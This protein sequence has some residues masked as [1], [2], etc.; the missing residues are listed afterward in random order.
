MATQFSR[1]HLLNGVVRSLRG[2][3]KL[4]KA[5]DTTGASLTGGDVLVRALVLRRLLRRSALQPDER[6]VGVLLPPTCAA[7]VTNLALTLDGRVVINL[8][9]TLTSTLINKCIAQAGITHV[10]TS[11]AFMER[12]PLELDGELVYLEDFK[13]AAT[14]VDKA[15]GAFQAYVMPVGLLT[16]SL[17]GEELGPDEPMTILFTSGTTG[18]PKGVVL[19]YGNVGSNVDAIDRIIKTRRPDVMLGILPFFHSFGYTVAL[20][21]VLL[22][23]VEAAYHSNPL[24][25]QV[26]GR[27][28]R[29]RKVTILIATP[30]FFRTFIRRCEPEDFRSVQAAITGA[31]RLPPEVADEFEAK[32]GMRPTQGYGCTETSPLIAATVPLHRAVPG[33][34]PPI[35]EGTVGTAAPGV[36]IKAV[37]PVTWEEVPPGERGMLLAKGPNVMAGYLDKPEETA[38][39]IRDGW[40]VTGDYATIDVEGYV[41]IVGRESRFAKIGGEMVSHLAVEEALTKIVGTTEDG[42]PRLVVVSAPDRDRGER[43]IVVHTG[44][45]QTPDELRQA[46]AA[47][48]LP[49]LYIP[50]GDSY[51]QIEEM[52]YIGTGKLDLRKI[53]E[54]ANEFAASHSRR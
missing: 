20:W 28:V 48:D 10:L 29:E 46:L 15:I 23:D 1:A 32:F 19:T 38:K 40:Y 31:E 43:L 14:A 36:A 8:N 30:M 6:R 53:R 7:A 22:N 52:P 41:T 24:E 25:A 5:T 16:K 44:L 35:K 21:T 39:V 4:T 50:G 11:R 45:E 26:I 17:G 12:V 34:S 42:A 49:N 47:S 2:W 51:V 9:Y 13:T 18:D 33:Q 3:R 54:V 27:I 37:D